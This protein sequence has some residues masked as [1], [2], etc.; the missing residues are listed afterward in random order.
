[1]KNDS[2]D[3]IVV[4]HL[5]VERGMTKQEYFAA[6]AMQGILANPNVVGMNYSD[7]ANM[8]ITQTNALLNALEAEKGK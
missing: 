3:V 8:A 6:L 1:M 7:L 2:A 4:G 5:L